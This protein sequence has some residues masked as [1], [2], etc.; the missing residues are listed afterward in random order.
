MEAGYEGIGYW[1]MQRLGY[2]LWIWWT[3]YRGRTM[4]HHGGGLASCRVI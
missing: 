2:E 4:D 3:K 1:E